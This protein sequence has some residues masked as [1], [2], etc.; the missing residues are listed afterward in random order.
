MA[1]PATQ[2]YIDENYHNW[3]RNVV[4]IE[5]NDYF[6]N[7]YDCISEK[8]RHPGKGH[9]Y[10]YIK[11]LY[12]PRDV[13]F[14][15]IDIMKVGGVTFC[16][17]LWNE[18]EESL[19]TILEESR[20]L[21]EVIQPLEKLL[22]YSQSIPTYYDSEIFEGYNVY[23]TDKYKKIT[24]ARP[25]LLSEWLFFVVD[26]ETKMKDGDFFVEYYTFHSDTELKPHPSEDI[27][28]GTE[29]GELG[30]LLEDDLYKLSEIDAY[31]H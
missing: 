23:L 31:Y 10:Y 14:A 4:Q 19:E 9:L 25:L 20:Q 2:K 30:E 3:E 28:C 13:I 5:A 18:T 16:D 17:I 15:R 11:Y 21:P 27:T 7:L 22:K 12:I 29:L 8:L 6:F 24:P 26:Y 1:D